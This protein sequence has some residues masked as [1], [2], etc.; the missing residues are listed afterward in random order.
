MAFS[1]KPYMNGCKCFLGA[2]AQKGFMFLKMKE[3]PLLPIAKKECK[4]KREFTVGDYKSLCKELK[5]FNCMG[6]WEMTKMDPDV[7]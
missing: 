5:S 2:A 7:E 6:H 3:M 4:G 1:S